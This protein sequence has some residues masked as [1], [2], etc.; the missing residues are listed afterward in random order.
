MAV[1]LI[2]YELRLA[3]VK[4]PESE[5]EK[6]PLATG[7]EMEH[8]YKHLEATLINTGFLDPN[9]PRT[10]MRRLRRLFVRAKMDQNEVN[11]LRGI[12]KAFERQAEKD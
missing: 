11:I 5:S 8:F 3:M 7:Q 4:K 1:Q 2:C 6:V 10:L 9:N 12:L